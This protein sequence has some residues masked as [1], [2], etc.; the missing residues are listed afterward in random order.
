MTTTAFRPIIKEATLTR[1]SDTSAY[2]VY[3]AVNNSTSAPVATK[4]ANLATSGGSGLVRLD[5]VRIKTNSTA[6]GNAIL[7]VHLFKDVN[8]A[9][10]ITT[11][12]NASMSSAIGAPYSAYIGAFDVT[13]DR[14]LTGGTDGAGLPIVGAAINCRLPEGHIY[15]L[16]ETRTAFTP[17]S[18]QTFTV[19]VEGVEFF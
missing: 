14:I 6:M 1:P 17:V 5:R 15:F 16:I 18:A 7:R 10:T 2:A 11:N 13:M 9:P 12:D 3:D 4:I 19:I 8:G